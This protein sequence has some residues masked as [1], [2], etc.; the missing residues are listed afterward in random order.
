MGRGSSRDR[1]LAAANHVI[2]RDGIGSLTLESV[3]SEAGLTKGG[4]QYHF[5]S[6]TDLMHAV[7]REI[8]RRTEEAALRC[9]PV[10]LDEATPDQRLGAIIR[11]QAQEDIPRAELHVVLN[12]STGGQVDE[13]REEF[14]ARWTGEDVRPLSAPQWVA[15]LASEGLW[16]RDALGD[17]IPP[18]LREEIV[19]TLLTLAGAEPRP[20]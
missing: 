19:Q 6:K 16:L 5:P 3:A 4:L 8:W 12:S 20:S 17:E 15:L 11:S 2:E 1:V 18:H 14:I 13:Q 7:E 9:L 10:P